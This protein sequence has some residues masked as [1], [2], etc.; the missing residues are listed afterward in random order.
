M[1][2]KKSMKDCAFNY[3]VKHEKPSD[4]RKSNK[5]QY[6]NTIDWKEAESYV[7]RL[8]VRIVKAV[9]KE[10][11]N[12]VKRLQY[13][14][15]HSFY[16]KALSVKR[17]TTNKGKKTA[18]IDNVLWKTAEE[19]MNAVNQ[20]KQKGYTAK[21]LKRVYI[22]KFGKKEKRPL[23]I[24]VMKDRA[25]QG[26]YL[27]ALEPIAETTA[28]RISFGFRKNRSAHDAM[29]YTFRLLAKQ[30]SPDWILEGDIKSCFDEISH[31]YLLKHIPMDKK[32]LKKFLK[33]GYIY[34]NELFPTTQGAAQ[35]GSLSPV[36]AN[37]V[38]EVWKKLLEKLSGVIRK[39]ELT[40][41]T[42]IR[43]ILILYVMLMTLL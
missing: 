28:D 3:V 40:R 11:W 16:A 21:P 34:Q 15:V 33:A 7:N 31:S 36:L 26:L 24:P 37:M 35:G 25:M 9:Q 29:E 12:L 14:L 43:G 5:N 18:G 17:V 20:L 23:S 39:E 30:S 41:V 13:L 8:Q 2:K 42:I 32:I 27:L 19:K 6:W 1:K 38:L 22:E 4:M 10:N